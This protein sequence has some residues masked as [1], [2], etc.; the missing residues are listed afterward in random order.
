MDKLGRGASGHGNVAD[1][2]VAKTQC[3][4]VLTEWLPVQ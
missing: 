1:F 2:T 3:A 4:H